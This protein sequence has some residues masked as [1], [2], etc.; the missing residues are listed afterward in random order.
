MAFVPGPF[1]AHP[2]SVPT[3]W[4]PVPWR[5]HTQK[6][7][8]PRCPTVPRRPQLLT[9]A[10]QEVPGR[11]KR[12]GGA[13]DLKEAGPWS[14]R[15]QPRPAP[16]WWILAQEGKLGLQGHP[17]PLGSS[18][19]GA[20]CN[21][22]GHSTWGSGPLRRVGD[23][24]GAPDYCPL[25]LCPLHSL[26][27]FWNLPFCPPHPQLLLAPPPPPPPWVLLCSAGTAAD[28]TL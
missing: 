11:R 1:S 24:G 19:T 28:S 12:E 23:K 2:S 27:G 9:W 3:H 6:P 21:S 7:H 20:P 8:I 17:G 18:L 4:D 16:P 5:P 10:V 14:R 22:R 13:W 26:S 25:P 15:I